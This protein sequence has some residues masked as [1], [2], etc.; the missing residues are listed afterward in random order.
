M[1]MQFDR[2]PNA[3]PASA[4]A[5]FSLMELM[6]V[7]AITGVLSALAI[8]SFTSYVLRA[9]TAE[10]TQFLGVIK[11]RQESYRAEFG[12][13]L[14]CGTETDP[15]QIAFVPNGASVMKNSVTV[16]FPTAPPNVCFSQLGARP[17]G[18][19][20]FGYGWVAGGPADLAGDVGD[21]Y[22]ITANTADNYFVA[23]ATSDL[24]G[25]GTACI[26]EVTSFTRNVWIGGTN[27][28]ALPAG[29]E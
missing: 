23:Q 22:G 18:A 21:L 12:S 24:D 19:V 1:I 15:K 5:G 13:Y 11:M 20:R 16:S 17:D 7:V 25:D 2:R 4:R 26:F 29:Y 3:T 6:I 27:G 14:P 10:A 28:V 8:P 9:R